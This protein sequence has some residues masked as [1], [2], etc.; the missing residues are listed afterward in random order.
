GAVVAADGSRHEGDV[1]VAATG[2]N[3]TRQPYAEL[4]TGRDGISLDQYWSEGMRAYA[5]TA[6]HGFPN[7][8]VLDGLN[9]TLAHNSA[10]L[11]I[12]AQ[13]D[14]VAS[15]LPWTERGPLEV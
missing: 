6:V 12:E 14:Y 11:M 4:I 13:A 5:S 1:V 10:V 3:T 2:F 7:L 8:F 15:A 9:A